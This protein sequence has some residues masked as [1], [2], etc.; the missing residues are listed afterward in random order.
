M[1]VPLWRS[2]QANVMRDYVLSG[3]V[4]IDGVT[5]YSYNDWMEKKE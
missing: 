5:W 1:V 2:A 4:K 3:Y